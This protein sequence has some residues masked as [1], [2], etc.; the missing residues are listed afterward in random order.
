[1]RPKAH[2]GLCLVLIMLASAPAHAQAWLKDRREAEGAG[3]RTGAFEL[4]PGIAAEAGFDSNWLLRSSSTRGGIANGGAAAP[5]LSFFVFRVTPHLFLSTRRELA[6]A[7]VFRLGAAATYR[8][9]VGFASSSDDS[10]NVSVNAEGHLDVYPGRAVSLALDL[11]YTRSVQPSA[12][13]LPEAAFDTSYPHAGI[14]VTAA[15]G[16]GGAFTASLGYSFGAMLFERAA[17]S[18]FT[19][20]RH[21]IQL[22]N[23]W[24]F[25]PRT[26]LFHET[27][28]GVI[29]YTEKE[30][31]LNVLTDSQPLRTRL[32][33]DGLVTP[34]LSVVLA[35][36][37]GA[38]FVDLAQSSARQ[39]DSIIGKA[40][41]TVYLTPPPAIQEDANV[42]LIQSK[43][44]LGYIRDFENSYLGNVVGTDKGA[45]DLSWLYGGKFLA[46]LSAS[47]AA[48]RYPEV[49][50]QNGR[51]QT[52]AF[53]LLRPDL[54]LYCEYRFSSSF[55]VN[56]TVQYTQVLHA[57]S[58]VILDYGSSTFAL[59]YARTQAFA[60]VRWF[61]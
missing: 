25:R 15:P 31:A 56:A 6:P 50:T 52:A 13:G 46:R 57:G 16:A 20:F 47:V 51:A 45:L 42:T 26:A 33:L 54:T 41:A 43:L 60:G 11:G 61:L 1:M 17:A 23:R 2:K 59:T 49:T 21:E 9:L 48:L 27:L 14:S 36:G 38:S 10:R 28:A 34:R 7:L 30:R 19:N 39:F 55:A 37:Y 5:R 58:E 40:E 35:A 22:K 8:E 3:V 44:S 4:H 18:P 29:H 24:Q 53:T 32:G 12:L